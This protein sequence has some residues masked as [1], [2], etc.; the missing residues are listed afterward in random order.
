MAYTYGLEKIEIAEIAGDGGPGTVF[1]Q[2]GYTNPGTTKFTTDSGTS[3]EKRCEE[4]AAPLVT[5]PGDETQTVEFQLIVSD[6]NT[7]P[8]V[9]GGAVV[10]T[11]WSAPDSKPVIEK[12]LKITPKSGLAIQCN[13]V[14]IVGSLNATLSKDGDLFYVDCKCTLLQ[15]TKVGT[16]RMTAE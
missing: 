5:I 10:A 4:L 1:S 11:K 6:V 9:L 7:L 3:T 13:R 15:P 12:T 8:K 14:S 2:I 16:A